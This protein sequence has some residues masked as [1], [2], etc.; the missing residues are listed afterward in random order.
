MDKT[1]LL[2]RM[3][4]QPHQYTE[5]QWQEILADETCR[6]LY[7]LMAKT[8]SAYHSPREISD[9]EIDAEWQRLQP[10]PT[11]V[12]EAGTI[13]EPITTIGMNV[14]KHRRWQR[15]A[16]M[17]IGMLMLSGIAFA[18]IHLVRQFSQQSPASNEQPPMTDTTEAKA[19]PALT[20][21]FHEEAATDTMPTA[22]SP[23]VFDNVSLDKI[24]SEIATFHHLGCEVQNGKATALRFYFVWRQNDSLQTVVRQLNQFEQ[25]NI[26]VDNDKLMVR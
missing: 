4:D 19:V 11:A 7:A 23:V 22:S 14:Q 26:T 15:M 17:F 5:R 13:S 25:V 20:P 6:E 21:V 8:K 24:A 2:L 1:E 3:M 18:A 16:A 9:E 12:A 10:S